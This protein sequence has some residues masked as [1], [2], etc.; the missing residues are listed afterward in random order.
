VSDR[1][2]SS[3]GVRL[4]ADPAPSAGEQT[5]QVDNTSAAY[6]AA[7]FAIPGNHDGSVF[8]DSADTPDTNV[9][10][11]PGVISSQQLE[12]RFPRPAHPTEPADQ[13]TVALS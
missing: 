2:V 7:I 4:F 12:I 10:E 1:S 5:F 8:G 11:G 6:D 13:V 3:G 9:L